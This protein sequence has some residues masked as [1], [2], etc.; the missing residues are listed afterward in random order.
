MIKITDEI[1]LRDFDAWSGAVETKNKILDAGKDEDFENYIEECYPDG[2]SLTQLND[3]LA[4]D[5]QRVL[6]D[7]DIEE[8]ETSEIIKIL[9]SDNMEE[10]KEAYKGDDTIEYELSEIIERNYKLSGQVRESQFDDIVEELDAE[11]E[12]ITEEEEETEE[13]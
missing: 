11:L 7:L 13:N 10:L 4:Y 3:I 8:I 12:E 9:K 2:L 1:T 5:S 6:E